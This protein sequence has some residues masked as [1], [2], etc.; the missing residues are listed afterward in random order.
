MGLL[1]LD[2]AVRGR[3]LGRRLMAAFE[4]WAAG[5]GAR[6]VMLSVVHENASALRFWAAIG[7]RKERELPP[8][9]FGRKTHARTEFVKRLDA[10]DNVAE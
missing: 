8:A 7:Y 3:G 1:L 6:R 10:P 2:P 5:R 4:R 9:Q